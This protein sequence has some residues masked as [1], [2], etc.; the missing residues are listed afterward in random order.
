MR[1][2]MHTNATVAITNGGKTATLTLNKQTLIAQLQSPSTA[3]FT[4]QNP[5]R[6]TSDPPLPTDAASQDQPNS[7]TVLVIALPAGSALIQVLFKYVPPPRC[8][9]D[10]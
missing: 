2:R 10:L 9:A 6:A 7:G 4:T 8:N 5:V 1:R 3:V